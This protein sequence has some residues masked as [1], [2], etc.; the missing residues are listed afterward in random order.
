MSD[1][2]AFRLAAVRR[3]GT[4]VVAVERDGALMALDALVGG[5][6]PATLREL[7]AGGPRWLDAIGDALTR[8]A[9]AL[10]GVTRAPPLIPRKL[11]CIGA[12]YNAHNAEMLGMLQQPF[13]YSFLK[14]PSTTVVADGATVQFPGYAEKLD[15]EA[16]LAVVIGAKGEVFG[17]APMNDLSV[18]DWVP[19]PTVLG[20]DWV[21]LKGFDGSAPLG[22]A[23]TP[24][25]FV[26]DPQALTIRSWV[27]GELRQDSSTSDMTFP[28]D[29]LVAHL[30]SVM[31]LEPGDVI[32]TGTPAGVGAGYS[33]PRFLAPGDVVTVE[34]E[35]LGRLTTRIGARHH[36]SRGEG[37]G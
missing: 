17:Y 16:E 23:I 12:N 13:P 36:N 37:D 2:P 18:R 25:R 31:T 27:N 1:E 22:P 7:I 20:M 14:P 26:D 10:N 4:E 28:V 5:D 3:D 6:A 30:R 32:A 19:G 15:Y 8:S 11:I 24:A 9:P 35:G 33:P 34:I 21:M 29:A